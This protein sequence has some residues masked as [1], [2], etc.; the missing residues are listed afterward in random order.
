MN[1]FKAWNV[2]KLRRKSFQVLAMGRT[3]LILAF[4]SLI[5]FIMLGLGGVAEKNFN[6]SPVS[7]MKGLA[8]TLNSRF[9]VSMMGMEVPHLQEP[10]ESQ[11]T[12]DGKKMTNFVFQLLTNVNPQD[13]KS[14]VAREV[15]GL[16]SSLPILLRGGT[17][18]EAPTAPEDYRPLPAD[19]V[20]SG[21]KGE[22]GS[23][24]QDKSTTDSSSPGT[25]SADPK[26]GE[27]NQGSQSQ[28][29]AVKQKQ[30][31]ILIYHSHPHESYNPLLGSN[32]ANPSSA[33]KSKNVGM[34]GDFLAKELEKKGVGALHSFEDYMSSVKSYN[35]N[36]SY[37]YSRV[38][39]KEA[40]AQHEDLDYFIDIHRDS[41]RHKKTTITIDGVSYAQLYFIIGHGNPNWRKNEAFAN[42]IHERIEKAYPGL[43]RGIWGKTS[44]QGNGEYNQSLSPNSVLIEIGGIDNTK[45][46]LERSSK[47][48]AD[49]IAEVYFKDQKAKKASTGAKTKEPAASP[50]SKTGQ[51]KEKAKSQTTPPAGVQKTH[52]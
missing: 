35:Y 21:Q 15:P 11:H 9:F 14:L 19:T 51:G 3:L 32:S 27:D 33:A 7:S 1:G 31:S 16:D 34:V 38:T 29:G 42:S 40:L 28:E 44:S 52:S 10:E 50:G 30:K 25:K 2:G 41:Q 22:T 43:S 37:K 13:P 36:Y 48:L 17:S 12:F 49:I 18:G 8:S 24:G 4:M 23:S 46:E 45:E 20:K 5:L 26:A 39:V 47:V 6:T